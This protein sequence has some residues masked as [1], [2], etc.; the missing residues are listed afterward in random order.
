MKS[1][2]GYLLIALG[3]V[4]LFSVSCD[5]NSAKSK[6]KE[7]TTKQAG[8]QQ[9]EKIEPV[10]IKDSLGN[11][12]ERHTNSYRKKDGSLRSSDKYFYSYDCNKNLIHEIKESYSPDGILQFKNVNFYDFNE[13]N[14]NIELRFESYDGNGELQR[15]ARHT[16]AYDKNGFKIED[17]GYFDNGSI[18]S[19]IILDPDEKGA[20]RSEEYIYYTEEGTITSDKKYYYS[21]TGLEKTVDLL[22][23]K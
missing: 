8:Q 9:S 1:K 6:H 21:S 13:L 22:K 12:I 5:N 2:L 16:F 10:V 11:V 17:I 18:M 3:I 19:R 20:L 7:K 4:F 23:E 15:K 14:Q